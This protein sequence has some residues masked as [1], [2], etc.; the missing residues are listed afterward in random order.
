MNQRY[1]LTASFI[2]LFLVSFARAEDKLAERIEKIT[3]HQR[4][5]TAH[6][7]LLVVDMKTGEELY[8]H[9]PHKLFVPASTTK[10]YS[11]AAALDALGADYRFSTK[12]FVDAP[13]KA[14]SAPI[15]NK[16]YKVAG[17]RP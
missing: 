12:V 10:L 15:T 6:W 11:V 5:H 13:I 9:Q 7:G 1:I 16:T 3:N 4:Y 2:V 14:V 8:A 17:A